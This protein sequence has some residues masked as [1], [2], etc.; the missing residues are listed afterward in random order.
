MLEVSVNFTGGGLVEDEGR[1]GDLDLGV[2]E[3]LCF[4]GGEGEPSS[5][6]G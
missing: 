5:E 4:L 6:R 1:D 3:V 2:E